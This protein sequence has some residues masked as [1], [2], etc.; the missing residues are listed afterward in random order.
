MG[1][2]VLFGLSALNPTFK[3]AMAWFGWVWARVPSG[4]VGV[5]HTHSPKQRPHLQ[6]NLC[7]IFSI[8]VEPEKSVW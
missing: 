7:G 3:L 1:W 6:P 4:T 8:R 2:A 5:A